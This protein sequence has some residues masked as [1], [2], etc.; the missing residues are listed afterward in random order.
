MMHNEWVIIGII[1]VFAESFACLYFLHNRYK[2]KYDA[3]WPQ[4]AALCALSLWELIAIFFHIPMYDFE[5]PVY[6]LIMCL[7]MLLYLHF[8]KCGSI[9]LKL[10]GVLSAYGVIMGT[11]ILGG[12]LAVAIT[13]FTTTEHSVE[14]QNN[15]S[16][17]AYTFVS[18]LQVV[19]FYILAKKHTRVRNLQKSPALVL[20]AAAVI[21][22]I[23][24][25]MLLANVQAPDASDRLS[26]LFM[27]LAT[28]GV[29]IL[30]A[31]F[32]AYELFV[33]EEIKSIELAVKVQRFE[34][35]TNF[36]KEIDVMYSDTRKWR[37]D[38]KNNLNSLRALIVQGEFGRARKYIDDICDEPYRNQT[39]LQ[40]GNLV[41]D[42]IISS[43]LWLAES[44]NIEI[45][46]QAVYPENNRIEDSDLCAIA[47]NLLDNAI[48]ACD[49][50]G[51]TS[52]KRFINFSLLTKGK[53]LLLSISNSYNNE[54]KCG[55][56][57]YLTVK[58]EAYHGMGLPHV[59]SIVNK[60]KGHVMRSGK[61]SVF[62][63]HIMLPLLPPDVADL[64]GIKE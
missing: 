41:L 26:I 37:H 11:L 17:L 34:L 19:V 63:T 61:E 33:R 53:N 3:F 59:D 47:G 60:Y 48:E 22:F 30:I 51:E 8:F 2:S 56:N 54:L 40:T 29:F 24:I 27:R 39:T 5:R 46:I 36:Y 16:L 15:S 55:G 45:N 58:K 49:R 25:Y 9:F 20:S 1:W 32:L 6:E 18:V 31:L 43:K 23:I 21:D 62:E 44:K 64:N 57:R 42:A 52:E 38:Y 50:M 35:E 10:L 28:G 7:I 14:Y 4:L 13:A 12:G